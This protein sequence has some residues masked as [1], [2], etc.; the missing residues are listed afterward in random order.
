M[1]QHIN[2]LKMQALQTQMNPHFIFNVLSSIQDL[3]VDE[4]NKE[5]LLYIARFAKLIR[6]IFEKSSELTIPIAQEIK[7]IQLYLELEQLRFHQKIDIQLNISP[8][9]LDGDQLVPPLLIQPILENSFKHGLMHK[10]KGG[11]L[12]LVLHEKDNGIYC[13]VEDNGVGRIKANEYTKW[14]NQNINSNRTSGLVVTQ[15]RLDILSQE[16]N[17][18]SNFLI[19]DLM[20]EKQEPVGTKTEFLIPFNSKFF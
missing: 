14:K 4:K 10:E 11:S 8:S 6:F 2:A 16:T 12:S 3:I 18:P 19:T 20:N 13:C 15:K 7:F 17:C 9:L 5:A 1:L